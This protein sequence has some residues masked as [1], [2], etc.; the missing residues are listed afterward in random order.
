MKKFISIL[1][2]A[3]MLFC[4]CTNASSG[5]GKN[6][7]TTGGSVVSYH[8][9]PDNLNYTPTG[10]V[11]DSTLR[12]TADVTSYKTNEQVDNFVTYPVFDISGEYTYLIRS[13]PEEFTTGDEYYAFIAGEG[14]NFG[15]EIYKTPDYTSPVETVYLEDFEG[16][17]YSPR[18][19]EYDSASNTFRLLINENFDEEYIYMLYRFDRDGK[20]IDS[21]EADPSGY[22]DYIIFGGKLYSVKNNGNSHTLG[23]LKCE[24]PFAE[25]E[26]VIHEKALCVFVSDNRLYF[27]ANDVLPDYSTMYRLYSYDPESSTKTAIMD[28]ENGERY[29]SASYDAENGIL[30]CSDL[31]EIYAIRDGEASLVLNTY[32]ASTALQCVDN[33]YIFMTLGLNQLSLYMTDSAPDSLDDSKMVL[34]VCYPIETDGTNLWSDALTIMNASGLSVELE[35]VYSSSSEEEYVNTMAK[36]FLAGDTDFDIFVVSEE[37][38]ELFVSEYYADLAAFDVLRDRF[39]HMIPGMSEL[40]SIDGKKA[41]LPSGS[42]TLTSVF[43]TDFAYAETY[44]MPES[45]SDL[46]A[47]DATLDENV[48][49]WSMKNTFNLFE[50]RFDNLADNFMAK[51]VSDEQTKSDILRLFKE[52]AESV[53]NPAIKLGSGYSDCKSIY[54]VRNHQ[55]TRELVIPVQNV[56]EGYKN[57]VN[58]M[59]FG[60]NPNSPNQILAASF[61]A[62]YFNTAHEWSEQN[63]YFTDRSETLL[64]YYETRMSNGE[65]IRETYSHYLTLI[66]N[67]VRGSEIEGMRSLLFDLCIGVEQGTTTPTEA[68]D[69]LYR[70]VKMA[71]DE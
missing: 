28:I 15:I 69:E 56:G 3:A 44:G 38:S 60:I 25:S 62:Y 27:V 67:S 26:T 9:D 59:F 19:L 50:H 45:Y 57:S 49:L 48:Y 68:A 33:G 53:T 10:G 63:L 12:H 5:H 32:K 36:K 34:R 18:A 61:I 40:M 30:Y 7:K 22:E 31:S 46:L 1:I 21:T 55:G 43:Y 13:F 65:N 64:N 42:L 47:P 8:V 54:T 2:L 20:Y 11:I 51:T 35:I 24:D 16:K 6:D 37:M 39:D 66:E 70:F 23:K 14:E 58:G 71:R 41:L 29:T 52:A 4:S 17:K